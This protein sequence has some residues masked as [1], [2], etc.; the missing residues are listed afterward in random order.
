MWELW[1]IMC[2]WLVDCLAHHL[3]SSAI[4]TVQLS[5]HT[6]GAHIDSCAMLWSDTSHSSSCCTHR[7]DI[8][9]YWSF[10]VQ[11]PHSE[12]GTHIDSCARLWSDTFI[13]FKFL[14]HSWSE[15][16]RRFGVLGF[17]RH[18]AQTYRCRQFM[19]H[20]VEWLHIS[21]ICDW[22]C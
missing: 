2:S 7:Q 6:Y 3:V 15:L 4:S 20:M 10:A 18:I 9:A 16:H 14:L 21:N 1:N 12:H 5:E 19:L 8:I 13:S 22:F 11:T 17:R